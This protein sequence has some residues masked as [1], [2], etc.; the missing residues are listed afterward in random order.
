MSSAKTSCTNKGQHRRWFV[1]KRRCR[2]LPLFHHHHR[3]LRRR[4]LIVTVRTGLDLS[5]KTVRRGWFNQRRQKW[6]RHVP[7]RHRIYLDRRRGLFLQPCQLLL[8]PPIDVRILLQILCHL[9]FG[10]EVFIFE[11]KKKVKLLGMKKGEL[12]IES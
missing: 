9:G 8:L 10:C 1:T 2:M 11:E 3:L 4:L 5:W 12:D 6:D 7:I